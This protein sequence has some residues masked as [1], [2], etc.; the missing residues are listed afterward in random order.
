MA[1]TLL[2]FGKMRNFLQIVFVA[3]MAA[4][5]V[6]TIVAWLLAGKITSE[7]PSGRLPS[8]VLIAVGAVLSLAAV[9]TAAA[10]PALARSRFANATVA[11]KLQ[12]I[13]FA[14]VL[15]GASLEAAGI[16]W[17]LLGMLLANRLLLI[18]PAAC[19]L[20]TAMYFPTQ[21]R[22]EAS[23]EMSEEQADRALAALEAGK[24]NR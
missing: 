17:A 5:V 6:F 14:N 23:L 16:Y 10:L 3:M 7:V 20:I 24:G 11:Q 12:G 18:G 15:L 13:V 21:G 1:G 9:A 4:L 22:I 2:S 8:N 19:F